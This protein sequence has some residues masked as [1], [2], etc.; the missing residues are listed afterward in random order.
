MQ[1]ERSSRA[2]LLACWRCST[3]STTQ[4]YPNGSPDG[5]IGDAIFGQVRQAADLPIG[6]FAA[7]F[8]F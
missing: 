4:F 3:S 7:R 2:G 6:Q 8:T 5:N 1:P